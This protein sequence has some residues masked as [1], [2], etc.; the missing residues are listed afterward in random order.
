MRRTIGFFLGVLV[1][2]IASG[3]G[4][5]S[6][7]PH[8]CEK[9][10]QAWQQAK[11]AVA[12]AKENRDLAGKQ[13]TERA[14][15]KENA[16]TYLGL[17]RQEM[18]AAEDAYDAARTKYADCVV[19]HR[20]DPEAGQDMACS[21]EKSEMDQRGVLYNQA[22]QAYNDAKK[23][24]DEALADYGRALANLRQAETELVIAYIKCAQ[25]YDAYQACNKHMA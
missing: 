6:P 15:A 5:N 17:A 4:P 20:N 24:Y 22:L 18:Y 9:E 8:K 23:Q 12:T 14:I 16:K 19:E 13:V 7:V 21:L 10:F 1:L 25:A 3:A 2:A 11:A